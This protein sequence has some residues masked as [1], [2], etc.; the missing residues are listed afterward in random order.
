MGS[1]GAVVSDIMHL[2]EQFQEGQ[3]SFVPREANAV[4]HAL[5]KLAYDYV[6]E[7]L[8]VNDFPS[9]TLPRV[10]SELVSV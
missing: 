2:L 1:Y 9:I 10:L 3:V 5:A 6:P 7:R 4:A 8:W